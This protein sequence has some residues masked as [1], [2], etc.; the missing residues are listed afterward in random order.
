ME[1]PQF[2][3]PLLPKLDLSKVLT[4]KALVFVLSVFFIIYSIFSLILFYHWF[5]YGMKNWGIFVGSVVFSVVSV[6]LFIV[7]ISALS[8]LN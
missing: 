1:L 5:T 3:L 7:S 2:S 6:V 8:Y 4:P